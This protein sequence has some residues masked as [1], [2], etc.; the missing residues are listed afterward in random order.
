MA[1]KVPSAMTA[2]A[3]RNFE[4]TWMKWSARIWEVCR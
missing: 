2:G 4:Y 1:P 3:W